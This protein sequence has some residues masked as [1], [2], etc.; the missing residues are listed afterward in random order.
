MNMIPMHQRRIG[1]AP[2]WW[3]VAPPALRRSCRR[4]D[5]ALPDHVLDGVHP[6]VRDQPS[7]DLVTEPFVDRVHWQKHEVDGV[8]DVVI[9]ANHMTACAAAWTEAAY[10]CEL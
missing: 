1:R 2:T 8:A 9:A 7:S 10:L 6:S 3:C 4:P 5:A